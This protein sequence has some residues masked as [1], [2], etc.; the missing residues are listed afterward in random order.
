MHFIGLFFGSQLAS[1][2]FSTA[3]TVLPLHSVFLITITSSFFCVETQVVPQINTIKPSGQLLYLSSTPI[4]LLIKGNNPQ[5]TFQV[6]HV[7]ACVG[8]DGR[9]QRGGHSIL[10]YNY[11]RLF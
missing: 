7:N 9:R 1:Q 2:T 11:V 3:H 5:N 8:V 4:T 10:T 6:V